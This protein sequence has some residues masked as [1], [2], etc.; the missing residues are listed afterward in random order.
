MV[1]YI[2]FE[3]YIWGHPTQPLIDSL[4]M[5]P[6]PI[7]QGFDLIILSD[8]IFNH[9]QVRSVVL[10]PS[11]QYPHTHYGMPARCPPKNM[12]RC[13]KGSLTNRIRRA[14]TNCA[15]V[16]HTPPSAPRSPRF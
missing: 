13:L 9:S 2:F 14:C 12:R 11:I 4:P 7:S 10:P 3:G 5:S 8:L 1:D 15:S 6:N 16:L